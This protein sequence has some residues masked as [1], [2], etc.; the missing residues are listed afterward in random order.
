MPYL[1]QQQYSKLFDV[2]NEVDRWPR[3]AKPG[4]IDYLRGVAYWK[5]HKIK[6]AEKYMLQSYARDHNFFWCVADLALIYASSDQPQL[7]RASLAAPYIRQLQTQFSR[8]RDYPGY[9][10][11]ISNHLAT[12]H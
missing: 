1:Q 6:L 8:H 7:L 4:R 12:S 5:Q 9:M 2:L 3:I 11:K 10:K